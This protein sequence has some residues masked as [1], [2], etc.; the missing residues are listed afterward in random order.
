[1]IEYFRENTTGYDGRKNKID[2]KEVL[3]EQDFAVY[4]TLR[5]IRKK[6]ADTEGVPVYTIL[7]N[8]QLAEIVR[9]KITSK[10]ALSA[11]QG[12]G[13]KK[14]T[15]SERADNLRRVFSGTDFASCDHEYFRSYIRKIPN[16]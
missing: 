4:S 15:R 9:R 16:I 3:S 1:M 6:I 5:D 13:D 8:E 12:I 14:H 2:Y 10:N 11:I 7:T